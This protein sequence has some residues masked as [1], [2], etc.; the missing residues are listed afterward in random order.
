MDTVVYWEKDSSFQQ[1]NQIVSGSKVTNAAAERS[2]KFG[3]DYNEMNNND[4]AYFRMLNKHPG[5]SLTHQ[6]KLFQK[7]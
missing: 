4:K 5:L 3:S 7:I 2:V 1:I 6:N